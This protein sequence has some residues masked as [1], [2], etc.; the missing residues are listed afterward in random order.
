M[1]E[2]MKRIRIGSRESKLAVTQA[3]IIKAKILKQYPD[4][5]IHIITMKT[6]GDLI[7]DKS[8][9]LIGGKGLF[10]KELDLALQEGRIDLAVHSL[11]D[12]PMEGLADFPVFAY[13]EREDPRDAIIY[14]PGHTDIL[15]GGVIATS[16]RRRSIQLKKL[17]PNCEFIGIRGNVQ[18]RLAKLSQQ[19]IDGT[20]L[21]AAGLYRL[22]MHEVIGRIFSID[23]VLPPAGQGILAV[24][25]SIEIA[26]WLRDC[27]NDRNSES[28]ALA[29][30][31]FVRVLDGGCSSPIAAY[32]R[33]LGQDM[34][35]AGLYYREGDDSFYVE[36]I[37]GAVER[38]ENSGEQ[39]AKEMK[40]KYE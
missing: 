26:A 11:K 28:A 3:E 40:Q 1:Q 37:V 5:E 7:L 31:Q 30:R 35:L 32:A 20:I 12:M 39:L 18:T 15:P 10:V 4:T 6:T 19:N 36:R 17:Y 21:A 22:K 16:S 23:E 14:K 33:V 38:A 9:E 24:Q 25:G 2:P 27:L 29:E 13:T 34:E 8:L